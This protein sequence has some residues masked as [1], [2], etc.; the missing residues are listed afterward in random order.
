MDF[1]LKVPEH[2]P[3]YPSYYANMTPTGF[4]SIPSNVR[5]Y[6]HATLIGRKVLPGT[7][8]PKN[9]E[10]RKSLTLDDQQ[11]FLRKSP[12]NNGGAAG[13]CKK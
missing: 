6:V 8:G 2:S 13:G 3:S 11:C 10:I 4:Q 5:Y 12:D 9:A 1:R 7:D